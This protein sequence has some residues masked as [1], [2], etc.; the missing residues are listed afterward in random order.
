MVSRLSL[1]SLRQRE[2][3]SAVVE[4]YG[5]D[6]MVVLWNEVKGILGSCNSYF[7]VVVVWGY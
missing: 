6:K 1:L 2:G 3:S 7:V 4:S 5:T